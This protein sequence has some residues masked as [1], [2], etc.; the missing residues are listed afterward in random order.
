MRIRRDP[1]GRLLEIEGPD[2]SSVLLAYCANQD[3]SDRYKPVE[4]TSTVPPLPGTK[5]GIIHDELD[6]EHRYAIYIRR[7]LDNR[8]WIAG[9]GRQPLAALAAPDI[10]ADAPRSPVVTR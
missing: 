7:T 5:L 1:N 2:P 4:L 9:D 10:P 6:L 3:P 8:R